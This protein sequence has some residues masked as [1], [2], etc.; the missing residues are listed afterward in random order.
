M[1]AHMYRWL[2]ARTLWCPV[3][4]RQGC[5]GA[6]RGEAHAG[7]SLSLSLAFSL[8][9]SVSLSLSLSRARSLARS[10]IYVCVC[11]CIYVCMHMYMYDIQD[12]CKYTH[13]HEIGTDHEQFVIMC[14]QFDTRTHPDP[15]I[16]PSHHVYIHI[17]YILYTH[18]YT[19]YVY[20]YIHIHIHTYTYVY[21]Y[22]YIYTY[23]QTNRSWW[24]WPRHRRA[25]TSCTWTTRLRPPARSPL[26]D[27][28]CRALL[29]LH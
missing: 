13:T 11:V 2:A 14:N 20:I 7:F 17:I 6:H 12:I 21:M 22:T 27:Q 8:S 18:I 9:L 4:A 15:S 24:I 1:C 29:P 3:H 26:W 28:V 19:L 10:L 25:Y 16:R 23:I 5:Q